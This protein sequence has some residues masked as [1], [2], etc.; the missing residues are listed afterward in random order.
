MR[1]LSPKAKLYMGFVYLAG[2]AL[3]WLNIGKLDGVNAWVL[4]ILC[5][6]GSF[7]LVTKIEGATN[8]SHYNISFLVYSFTFITM[9]LPSTIVVIVVS[10]IV[11]WAWNKYEWYV[12][13]F[14]LT[15]YV[16]AVQISAIVYDLVNPS[17]VIFGWEFLI[18]V[19]AA[20]AVFT[21]ANHLLIGIIVWL[22]RG[23]NFIQSGI[24]G[25]F[26]LMMDYTM[27][28]MG[29]VTALLW[30]FNPYSV[31]LAVIPLYLL[32]STL[33]VPAL[34]RQT[35]IDSKTGLYNARFFS[36]TL[37]TELARANRFDRPITV[38][39]ADLDLLRNINNT[40]GHLAGDQV[41]IGIA[42]II[43]NNVREYD[44][45]ARFGG[46]EYAIL[47]PETQSEQAFER[48]DTIRGLIEKADFTVPTSVT[49][50]KATISIGIAGRENHAQTA[51]DII[52]NADVA[53]Y[54]AKL[55][56]RNRT[57]VYQHQISD[58][59]FNTKQA[60]LVNTADTFEERKHYVA[61]YEPN[62]L[63]EAGIP[64]TVEQ[65]EQ[66]EQKEQKETLPPK[67]THNRPS[68]AVDIFIAGLTVV[69][70]IFLYFSFLAWQPSTDYTGAAIFVVL[71]VLTEGLSINIY[72]R[73]T[74]VSTS[75][76]PMLAGG[77]LFGPMGAALLS[78]AFALVSGVKHGSK[79][80]RYVFNFSNQLIA[81]LIYLGGIQLT[82]KSLAEWDLLTQFII[83][84]FA[85]LIVYIVTTMLISVVVDLNL[86]QP[87]LEFWRE[88]FSWLAP[89]YVTM[90]LI[91]Y[92]FFHGYTNGGLVGIVAII[93]P[94][95]LLKFSEAQYI[96][97]TKGV[98]KQLREKNLTLEKSSSEITRLNEELLDALAH[99][100][101]LRDPYV[102]DHSQHVSKYAVMI[103]DELG[104][105]A[106]RVAQIRKAGLLHDIGKLGIPESILFKPGRL[107]ADEYNSIRRHSNLGA[108]MI[109]KVHSLQH[110]VPIVRHHHEHWDGKGYPEGLT[111][112]N[113]PLEAR[114]LS[115]A[116][117]VEAMA[118]DRP[119]RRGLP[120]VEVIQELERNSGTQ[121]D[122][123]VVCAFI[124]AVN[125]Q[126][127]P[128][129]VNL[130][131]KDESIFSFR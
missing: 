62:F 15:S 63:R 64:Q 7:A 102:L 5:G 106:G 31:L 105:P 25:F 99:I 119:Y 14:N 83:V 56:G 88:N 47:M 97:R 8:R 29:A 109:A 128:V 4:T 96:Q 94:L 122:P 11:E 43:K 18:A 101:D 19:M 104:L 115:V 73:D 40:Y 131:N 34:E 68:W 82:G 39:M 49:A 121:F 130:A 9:G 6:L 90:G 48:M 113:I 124:D 12:Q 112:K 59:L 80:N 116:D 13:I 41:L 50:I 95:L 86:G 22:A 93:G 51:N 38:V 69:A 16:L 108:E 107:S 66:E 55:S 65:E 98:V 20:M 89:Y 125:K 30:I 58:V 75:A 54:N 24:F 81:A 26:S 27:L 44:V 23:E 118:S 45:V 123:E 111:G 57:M 35:E 52:H 85:S 53:L 1:S 2:I 126:E 100:I 72:A 103:A 61:S 117:A 114:I 70:L 127:K 91:A 79:L 77:L 28:C 46:E 32:Y 129:I 87:F 76:A 78:L 21:L 120:Q 42:E 3:V 92:A 71:V 33:R 60:E 67:L 10:H 36:E 17:Q 84:F 37:E 110:L 74:A